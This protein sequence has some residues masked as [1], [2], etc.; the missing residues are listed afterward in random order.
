MGLDGAVHKMLETELHFAY[1]VHRYSLDSFGR[2]VYSDNY[3]EQLTRMFERR[4]IH[5]S[6]RRG[7]IQSSGWYIWKTHMDLRDSYMVICNE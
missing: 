7:H 5:V 1:A 3:R 2:Y 4:D 6:T